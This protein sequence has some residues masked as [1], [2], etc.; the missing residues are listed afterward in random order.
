M[1]PT[2]KSDRSQG[3]R[4]GNR[5]FTLVELL[6]VIAII[7][8]L[9]ALL[10]PA[11]QAAREAARRMQCAN[12]FKQ[13]GLAL[14]NYHAARNTFPPGVILSH[15]D[16]ASNPDCA[17]LLPGV[18]SSTYYIG[19]GW[20]VF[21]L[22]YLEEETLYNQFELDKSLFPAGNPWASLK[23]FQLSATKISTYLCPSDPNSGNLVE[24][25][26]AGTNGPNAKDDVAD[27]NIAGVTD[28]EDW[29]CDGVWPKSL[30]SPLA[31]GI[32]AERFGCRIKQI[33]DG[34]SKTL[35]VGEVTGDLAEER[36]NFPW[37]TLNLSDTRAINSELTLP[38]GEN[39]ANLDDIRG[40]G[41][42]SW[43]AGGCHFAYADGSVHFVSDEIAHQVLQSLTT[44]AGGEVF[45]DEAN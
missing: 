13:V 18:G 10:L 30:K 20:G 4:A 44:R 43:H 38:G 2:S 23:N 12:H 39:P 27:A 17:P 29:T 21:V 28:W 31:R 3:K 22:P 40:R 24:F 32:M 34:T 33:T 25:T 19:F 5:A 9:V 8:V 16:T 45:G 35:I 15:N 26:G 6:V 37:A 7:G 42:S 36:M 41:F 11:V 1:Q 14:H